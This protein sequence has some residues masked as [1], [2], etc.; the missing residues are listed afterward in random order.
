PALYATTREFLDYFNLKSLSELPTLAEIRDLDSINRE[1]ELKDP[2]L[3]QPEEQD[4]QQASVAEA[5]LEPSDSTEAGSFDEAAAD[6]ELAPETLIEADPDGET[7]SGVMHQSPA[8]DE[9]DTGTAADDLIEF[10]PD[11][12]TDTTTESHGI[13]DQQAKRTDETE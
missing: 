9:T 7:D 4:D 13:P 11:G 5:E 8:P 3:Y 1:L 12:E 6:Y 10:D 2:D